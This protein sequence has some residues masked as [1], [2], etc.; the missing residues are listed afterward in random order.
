MKAKTSFPASDPLVFYGHNY[1]ISYLDNKNGDLLG[2]IGYLGSNRVPP[3]PSNLTIAQIKNHGE[4]ITRKSKTQA[5]LFA[6]ISRVMTLG[7][8]K[9]IRDYLK[10]EYQEDERIEKCKSWFWQG[11]LVQK[12]WSKK[13]SKRYSQIFSIANSARLLGSKPFDSRIVQKILV[14]VLEIFE[15]ITIGLEDYKDC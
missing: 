3:L 11:N 1:H 5:C 6:A 13:P 2:C 8:T 9:A 12:W 10:K 4:K 15:T 14:T 7:S